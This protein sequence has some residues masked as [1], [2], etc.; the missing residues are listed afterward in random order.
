MFTCLQRRHYYK[1]LL[2]VWIN[3][4][5]HWGKHAPQLYNPPRNYIAIFDEYPMEKTH[6]ILRS[7]T[8]GSASPDELSKKAKYIFQ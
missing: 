2:L 4:C 5:S 1:A 8:K 3:M 6:S 7:Q